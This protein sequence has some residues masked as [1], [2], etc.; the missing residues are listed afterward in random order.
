MEENEKKTEDGERPEAFQKLLRKTSPWLKGLA[1]C[2]QFV[3]A[4][5]QFIEW[6]G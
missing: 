3:Y 4:V 5:G 2:A 6:L 1:R